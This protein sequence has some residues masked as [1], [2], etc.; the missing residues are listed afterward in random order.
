M[1]ESAKALTIPDNKSFVTAN[2]PFASRLGKKS[3]I[4]KKDGAIMR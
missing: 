2:K 1:L 4:V 3:R